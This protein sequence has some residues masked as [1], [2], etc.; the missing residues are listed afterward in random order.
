MV[1]SYGRSDD[2]GAV[3]G[4]GIS[5][6]VIDMTASSRLRA[7]SASLHVVGIEASRLCVAVSLGR[8]RERA[9]VLLIQQARR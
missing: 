5:A 2:V 8:A 7:G 9:K 6:D 1:L 4:A 3:M